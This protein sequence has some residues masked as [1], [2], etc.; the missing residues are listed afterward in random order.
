[1]K[2]SIF[3]SFTLFWIP[4][5][6]IYIPETNASSFAY[7]SDSIKITLR[8]GPSAEF[9]IVTILLSG[10]HVQVLDEQNGWSS[11]R[12]LDGSD[13]GK[14]GWVLSRYLM[15]RLPWMSQVEL[16]EKEKTSLNE[17]LVKFEKEWGEMSKRIKELTEKLQTTGGTL[18]KLK[19]DYE[20][21]KIGSSNYLSLRKEFES[22]KQQLTTTQERERKLSKEY[23]ELKLSLNFKWFITGALVVFFGW[24]IGWTMGRHQKKRRG[25]IIT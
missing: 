12:I 17:K 1:M 22:L 23:E 6:F 25:S 24:L 10:Q 14:E 9:K 16:L 15:T 2:K 4:L 3:Y 18:G 20:S 8:R 5:F 11:V 21:L 13:K 7:V 19:A